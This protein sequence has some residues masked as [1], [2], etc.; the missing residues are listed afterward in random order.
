M[1]SMIRR[2]RPQWS[3]R[4]GGKFL[5][6]LSWQVVLLSEPFNSVIV[7]HFSRVVLIWR[8]HTARFFVYND[9]AALLAGGDEIIP[10]N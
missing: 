10:D 5:V 9:F 3:K 2:R 6:I 1:P 4:A 7:S 8:N